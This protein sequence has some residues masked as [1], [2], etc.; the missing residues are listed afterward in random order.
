MQI[1][2]LVVLAVVAALFPVS[3]HAYLD[4]GSASIAF[5]AI[6]AGLVGAVVTTKIYWKRLSGWVRRFFSGKPQK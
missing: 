6:I 5:Q 3:A 2:P 4:A 1:N